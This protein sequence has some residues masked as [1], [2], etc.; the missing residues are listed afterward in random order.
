VVFH[1]AGEMHAETMYEVETRTFNVEIPSVQLQDLREFGVMSDHAA[2]YRGGVLSLLAA[3]AYREFREGDDV[4][5]LIIEGLTLEIL[6]QARR[7]EL[8]NEIQRTPKWLVKAKDL[9][10]ARFAERLSLDEI[11]REVGVHP[12]YLGQAF[13]KHFNSTIGEYVRTLR[14][15]N[16]ARTL[17]TS[18]VSLAVLALEMGFT[19]QSHFCKSFKRIMGF[20]PAHYRREFRVQS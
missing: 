11:A 18:D 7:L 13:R 14:V 10:Q 6:G 8:S 20:T 15:Q 3:R 5:G 12:V 16:A 1:P 9:L 17:V 4:S 19:D 2:D